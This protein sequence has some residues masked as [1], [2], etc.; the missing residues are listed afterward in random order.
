MNYKYCYKMFFIFSVQQLIWFFWDIFA[1]L[2]EKV[3]YFKLVEKNP[4]KL[5]CRA[6][7]ILPTTLTRISKILLLLKA[8]TLI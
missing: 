2:A 4:S 7:F 8:K 3:M 6:D 5:K 1:K